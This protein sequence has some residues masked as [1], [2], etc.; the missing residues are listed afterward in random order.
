M[1]IRIKKQEPEIDIMSTNDSSNQDDIVSYT[2]EFVQ[3]V[4]LTESEYSEFGEEIDTDRQDE[5]FIYPKIT[6][7]EE[8]DIND[9]TWLPPN[10]LTPR[11]RKLIDCVYPKIEKPVSKKNK[12]K[13]N[14]TKESCVKKNGL[15][16]PKQVLECINVKAVNGTTTKKDC[17]SLSVK[18]CKPRKGM[19]TAKQRLGRILKIH[20]MRK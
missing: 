19:S 20:K 16:R 9:T 2:C 7:S 3:K 17:D 4:D 8:E 5:N 10:N 13:N 15:P 1:I 6:H 18:V 14:T 12:S 11:E